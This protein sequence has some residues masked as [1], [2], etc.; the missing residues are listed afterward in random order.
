MYYPHPGSTQVT[1]QSKI[2]FTAVCSVWMLGKQLSL[3]QWLSLV[4][5]AAGVVCVQAPAVRLSLVEL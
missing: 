1:Y 2:F 4:L 5:L 3:T